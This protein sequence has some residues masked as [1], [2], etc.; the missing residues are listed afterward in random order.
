MN[1]E[2]L[3]RGKRLDNGKWIEGNFI[4]RGQTGLEYIRNNDSLLK[5]DPA[6]VEQFMGLTDKYT[7]K[8]IFYERSRRSRNERGAYKG[9][10]EGAS[11]YLGS[12]D[13]RK[14]RDEE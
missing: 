8:M 14:A 4:R 3:F 13:W 2:I 5:V 9:T 1:R 11:C 12:R 6:T 7:K 10:V